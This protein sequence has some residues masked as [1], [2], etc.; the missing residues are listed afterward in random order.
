MPQLCSLETLYRSSCA[1]GIEAEHPYA[2]RF[3]VKLE[4]NLVRLHEEL[5]RRP[6]QP[7][8]SVCFVIKQPKFL[9]NFSADF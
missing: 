2:L 1:A 3:E 4:E 9:E 8:R 6:D 5:E 7:S